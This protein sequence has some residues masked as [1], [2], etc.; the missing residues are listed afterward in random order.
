MATMNEAY[1]LTLFER[2][3]PRLVA[4]KGNKKAAADKKKRVRRQA[5][6]NVAV[7]L[8]LAV[9]IMG[10][11]GYFITCNVRLTEMNK[12]ISDR[13][14]QLSTLQSEKVRLE[15]ELASKTSAGQIDRYAL[16]NGML[17]VESSQIYYIAENGDDLVVVPQESQSWLRRVW[18]TLTG[19]LS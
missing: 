7:Y 13:Q 10:M 4:L 18:L 8:T 2:R 12:A 3:E 16:E 11:I 19:F 17:P 14:T 1:D 15:A 6:M 9:V 5:V